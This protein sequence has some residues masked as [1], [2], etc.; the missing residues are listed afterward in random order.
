MSKRGQITIFIIVGLVLLLL[1]GLY[2]AITNI[3]ASSSVE[4]DE[5]KAINFANQ[6]D[7]VNFYVTQCVKNSA[8][9]SIE[10]FGYLGS[11]LEPSEGSFQ[12]D[13]PIPAAYLRIGSRNLLPSIAEWET[14]LA[15]L[16]NYGLE[17]CDLSVFE[18]QGLSIEKGKISSKAAIG[19][20]GLVFNVKYPITIKQGSNIRQLDDYVVSV[21]VRL[22][23]LH[24]FLDDLIKEEISYP[25][26]IPVS[27]IVSYDLN[28]S[29]QRYE[30]QGTIVYQVI[31]DHSSQPYMFIFADKE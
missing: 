4:S 20:T 16:E 6:A 8:L 15:E 30:N 27:K 13:M 28:V 14:T 5:T 23:Y 17:V 11:V 22:E 24:G 10:F 21:P 19:D 12:T 3:L 1:A 25:G 18:N 26:Q 9:L 29:T 2:Y 31:D 7:N